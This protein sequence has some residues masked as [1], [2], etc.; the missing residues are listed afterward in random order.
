MC[1]FFVSIEFLRSKRQVYALSCSSVRSTS[2]A[3]HA[4]PRWVP[5]SPAD[6]RAA[7]HGM[8]PW[9]WQ[10]LRRWEHGSKPPAE[11]L[12]PKDKAEDSE[13]GD[14]KLLLLPFFYCSL[15]SHWT[16]S[17][18]FPLW[19]WGCSSFENK[20][21]AAFKVQANFLIPNILFWLTR[22][23]PIDNMG[24]FSLDNPQYEAIFGEDLSGLLVSAKA[25][26]G[27]PPSL[28]HRW[29]AA[30]AEGVVELGAG[31]TGLAGLMAARLLKC[32]CCLACVV[33]NCCRNVSLMQKCS[34]NGFQSE[35]LVKIGGCFF[36]HFFG[37]VSL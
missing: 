18:Q 13:L 15:L 37:G 25:K 24:E 22:I 20:S 6:A 1:P 17:P 14:R 33:W 21:L 35:Q 3:R 27:E 9:F 5:R 34:F 12:A 28:W 10:A 19:F 26:N 2:C 4:T 30:A 31:E 11:H 8:P 23:W 32:P 36:L 29:A 7:L 16:K